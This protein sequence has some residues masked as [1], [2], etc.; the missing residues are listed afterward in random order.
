MLNKKNK[1]RI[2]SYEIRKKKS[3]DNRANSSNFNKYNNGVSE[4]KKQRIKIIRTDGI[5]KDLSM[6]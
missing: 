1:E 2:F 3:I 6:S 5:K 4:E